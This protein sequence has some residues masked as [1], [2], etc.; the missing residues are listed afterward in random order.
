MGQEISTDRFSDEDFIRFRKNLQ[1]ETEQLAQ[2]FDPQAPSFPDCP[3]L[4]GGFELEACLIDANFD[5]A[6]I[7]QPFLECLNSPL[8]V[9]E[10]ARF[11]VE[12]NTNPQSLVNKC[13]SSIHAELEHTWQQCTRAA[14]SLDAHLLSIGILPTLCPE[15]IILDNMSDRA[16]YRALNQRLIQKRSDRQIHINIAEPETPTSCF[17]FDSPNIMIEAA[18]TS[19]Q[20]HLQIPPAAALRYFN[21]ATIL[22]APMVALSANSPYLFGRDLWCETRIPLFEQ[23]MT[24]DNSVRS[25]P[26]VSADQPASRVSLGQ[27]YLRQSMMECFV[28]NLK[29]FCILLPEVLALEPDRFNHL[30]LHNGTIW[31]WNRPLIGFNSDGL[32]HLRIE[33]R[34]VPAPTSVIDA[35]A[36]SAFFFGT[37]HTLATQATPPEAQMSF[38]QARANFYSASQQGLDARMTW[39][40]GSTSS[41]QELSLQELLPMARQGLAQLQL[42]HLDVERYL[43]IIQ[44][45]LQS[46]QT[47]AVWQRQFVRQR[48]ADMRSLVSAYLDNQYSGLPVH[49]WMI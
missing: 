40:D 7:N 20:I 10:L 34:V 31:R 2:W 17:S 22:S 35:V 45:R 13:L 16:R 41:I 15:H 18:A 46:G 43:G 8:V 1:Q 47:G 25:T 5:P 19:F 37:V 21:A 39:L 12:I 36:T 32:P 44:E 48:A 49:Q 3:T 30:R 29:D 23:I 26:N 33:H 24:I 42:D 4:T 11:N 6:P 28:E 27:G 38:A 9:E 14:Q